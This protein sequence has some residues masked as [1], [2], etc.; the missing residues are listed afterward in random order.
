MEVSIYLEGWQRQLPVQEQESKGFLSPFSTK[1][2]LKVEDE[3][4][5][6]LRFIRFLQVFRE[7]KTAANPRARIVLKIRIL[8]APVICYEIASSSTSVSSD[9][10]LGN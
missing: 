2:C 5:E 1:D 6:I 3:S 7:T 8:F 4:M 10:L 9:S